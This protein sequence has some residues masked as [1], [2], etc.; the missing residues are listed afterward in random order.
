MAENDEKLVY[1]PIPKFTR[2]EMEKAVSEN[3]IEKLIFVPLYASLYFEDRNFAENVCIKLSTHSNSR[4]RAMVI[5]GFDHIARI[6]GKLNKEIIKPIIEQSLKDEN[7]F[8][9]GK[10][11]DAKDG[12]E[13]FLKWKYKK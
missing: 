12:T 13:H 11:D 8:V 10:A 6:D 3:D 1:V 5:E 4:V 2:A 9:R 7:D